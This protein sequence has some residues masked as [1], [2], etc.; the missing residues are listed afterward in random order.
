MKT[1]AVPAAHSDPIFSQNMFAASFRSNTNSEYVFLCVR[2]SVRVC[3]TT[4]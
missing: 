4:V 3:V 1:V 2:S